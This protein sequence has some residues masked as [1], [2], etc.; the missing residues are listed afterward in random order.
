MTAELEKGTLVDGRYELKEFKGS[1]SFGEV[2]LAH[3]TELGV[4]V[5][6]K[7]YILLDSKGQQEF[8]EEYK[9]AY[10]LNHENL[11]AAT[12]YSVWQNRPYLI[13][14]YCGNGSANNYSG[15][16]QDELQIWQFIHDV[17]AGLK[18]LHSLEPAVVHQ[19]IKP[20]NIL[21]DDNGTFLISDFGISRKLRSTL[22]KQSKRAPQAGAI[23]YMGPERFLEEPLVVLTS[24][25][26][27]L[28]VSIYELINGDLPFGGQG[29]GML[30]SG[31]QLPKLNT[32]KWS[33]NLNKVM[34]ACLAKETWDRPTAA[35]LADYAQ[36]VIDMKKDNKEAEIIDWDK[37]TGKVGERI[38][39]KRK[40][41][42]PTIISTIAVATIAIFISIW[43]KPD[44]EQEAI[45][46]RHKILTKSVEIA[47]DAGDN[48]NYNALLVAKEKMDSLIDLEKKYPEIIKE[49]IKNNKTPQLRNQL[50]DECNSAHDA[51]IRSAEGQYVIAEDI[52]E[53]IKRYYIAYSLKKSSDVKSGIDKIANDK[54]ITAA[55]MN[56]TDTEI[57]DSNLRIVY[58]GI[59]DQDIDDVII[60]YKLTPIN[61]DASNI[62]EGQSNF[63][64][65]SGANRGVSIDL[66]PA[67]TEA[68]Y[69][70]ELYQNGH[71]FYRGRI[72]N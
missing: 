16:I 70:L 35:K 24:D 25:I 23:A 22:R 54:G 65:R 51:W 55:Y 2:W 21:V 12:Y 59:N 62:I 45:I 42:L 48:V 47:I 7:L 5:A 39:I 27:A 57:K 9:V 20:E 37:W 56:I 61:G 46:E 38:V 34:R 1:G 52:A 10:G 44:P 43:I 66:S 72:N 36:H 19:D 31:A 17:A 58:N 69:M 68:Q 63:T 53:A 64:L 29:G 33:E 6:I 41:L 18:F 32:Q 71:V 13:M 3:D 4:D 40:W 14:K 11:L 26:W 30:N 50:T 60:G 49:K 67:P 8:K 15:A 28:G